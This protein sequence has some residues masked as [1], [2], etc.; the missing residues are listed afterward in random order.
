[1]NKLRKISWLSKVFGPRKN[2]WSIGVQCHVNVSSNVKC[3]T[4]LT[5]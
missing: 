5:A 3:K 2:S 4:T 1:M